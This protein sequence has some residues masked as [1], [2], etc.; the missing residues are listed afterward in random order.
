LE[1]KWT[2]RE[3][4]A[5]SAQLDQNIELISKSPEMFS[6]SAKKKISEKL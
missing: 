4:G 1:K 5:F 2:K 6:A 3:I